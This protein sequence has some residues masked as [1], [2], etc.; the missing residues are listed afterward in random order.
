MTAL[1]AFH[2]CLRAR[3]QLQGDETI[4]KQLH[5]VLEASDPALESPEIGP[6]ASARAERSE[7]LA[8]YLSKCHD[9]WQ[10]TSAYFFEFQEFQLDSRFSG[11][12]NFYRNL[13]YS[14]VTQ[15]II[16]YEETGYEHIISEGS[17]SDTAESVFPIYF[18]CLPYIIE[19]MKAKGL[20]YPDVV[21]E[22]WFTML[23]RAWCWNQLHHLM[24]GKTVPSQYHN[25]ALPVFIA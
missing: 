7:L 14:H 8:G 21:A 17:V 3:T 5:W 13:L 12:F 19:D 1:A 2:G 15:I 18:Q 4:S 22:A 16:H 10:K 9:I 25:S 23:L 20:D 6:Q 24:P 11:G